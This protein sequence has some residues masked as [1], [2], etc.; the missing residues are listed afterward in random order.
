[1]MVIKIKKVKST[2]M[3]VKKQNLKFEDYEH[4][5]EA[6]HFGNKTNQQKKFIELK[7]EVNNYKKCKKQ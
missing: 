2:K 5:L 3:F 1:M 6:T 4:G 7:K